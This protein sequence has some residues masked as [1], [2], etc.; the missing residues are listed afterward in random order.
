HIPRCC[1]HPAPA[2]F[3]YAPSMM[4]GASTALYCIFGYCPK[5]VTRRVSRLWGTTWVNK[6]HGFP[7]RIISRAL[8]GAIGGFETTPERFI[9][10]L[11]QGDKYLALAD[12]L[13][14]QAE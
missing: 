8:C 12:A 1:G 2:S 7:A 9:T 4:Q 13:A 14:L 3:G 11:T 5:Q 6:Q 10:G